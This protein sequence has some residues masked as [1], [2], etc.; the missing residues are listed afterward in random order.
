MFFNTGS[1]VA[2]LII[3]AVM[4]ILYISQKA[5]CSDLGLE[6]GAVLKPTD[7]LENGLH[8]PF[9]SN[10]SMLLFKFFTAFGDSC[11]SRI[12]KCSILIFATIVLIKN[13]NVLTSIFMIF[14]DLILLQPCRDKV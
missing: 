7:L 6:K 13:Q 1:T 3:K 12:G 11:K 8:N 14:L 4:K 9:F 5:T 2:C 10:Y